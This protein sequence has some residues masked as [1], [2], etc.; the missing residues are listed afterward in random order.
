MF[1][2]FNF[3]YHHVQ[4]HVSKRIS[5]VRIG[6]VVDEQVVGALVVAAGGPSQRKFPQVGQTFVVGVFRR[7]LPLLILGQEET[8]CSNIF[9]IAKI[10]DQ[11]IGPGC[12]YQ[13]LSARHWRQLLP[14]LPPARCCCRQWPGAT[15]WLLFAK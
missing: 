4:N 3:T 14:N 13:S 11:K 6:V 1:I 5:V 15:H 10:S 7:L 9:E 12:C 2:F 8:P